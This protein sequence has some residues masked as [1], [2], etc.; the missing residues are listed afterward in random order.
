MMDSQ[1]YLKVEI[2]VGQQEIGDIVVAELSE[3]GFDGFQGDDCVLDCY[4]QKGLFDESAMAEVLRTL[5]EQ[6]PEPLTYRVEAVPDSDWNAEYEKTAFTPIVYGDFAVVPYDGEYNGPHTPIYLHPHLAF[7]DGH[8][9]TTGMM[10]EAMIMIGEMFPGAAVMDL[11]CGTAVLAILAAKMGAADVTAVDINE[12]AVR[13]AKE[14]LMLNGL[15]FPVLCGDSSALQPQVYDIILA[16]I[17]RNVLIEDMPVFRRSLKPGGRLL[18]SGFFSED[19]PDILAAAD[20]VGF[21][22]QTTL[23]RDIWYTI[24]LYI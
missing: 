8:H 2:P 6:L 10:M 18:I 22:A 9:Q 17:H 1:G 7:G 16:N 14:N 24:I 12:T 4:I 20:S 5:S 21:C 3:L 15:D 19:I 13:S 11:G 23:N